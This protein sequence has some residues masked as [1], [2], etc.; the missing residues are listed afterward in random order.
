MEKS[1][2]SATTLTGDDMELYNP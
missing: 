2:V 1:A